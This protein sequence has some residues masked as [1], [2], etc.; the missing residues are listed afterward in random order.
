M[1]TPVSSHLQVCLIKST[2]DDRLSTPVKKSAYSGSHR[3]CL[4]GTELSPAWTEA[5][6]L[7]KISNTFFTL[8]SA[9]AQI[10]TF[11]VSEDFSV[12]LL[13]VPCVQAL[14]CC[15]T[16]EEKQDSFLRHSSTIVNQ[17]MHLKMI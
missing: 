11:E 13:F 5:F 10:E 4:F 14:T 16:E 7:Y 9:S 12:N 15:T 2:H 3:A 17:D 6:A 1:V 8:S